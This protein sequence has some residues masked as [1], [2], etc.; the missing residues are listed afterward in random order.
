M[1]DTLHVL[2]AGAVQGVVKALHAR[3]ERESA[4]KLEARFGAVGAMKEA[5]LVGGLYQLKTGFKDCRA[6]GLV[7][8]A[9]LGVTISG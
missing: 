2:C 4:T 3:F 6:Y 7:K 8:C 9:G 1:S 5:L